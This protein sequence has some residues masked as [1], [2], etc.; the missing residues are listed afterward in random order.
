[1]PR[2]A[3]ELVSYLTLIIEAATDFESEAW[4][5]E[6]EIRCNQTDCRGKRHSRPVVEEDREI[7][8]WCPE[9]KNEGIITE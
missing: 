3:K 1:M 6:T 4:G 9:R 7:Y 5:F 8:W 2:E